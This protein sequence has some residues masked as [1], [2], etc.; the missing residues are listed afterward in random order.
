MAYLSLVSS[1]NGELVVGILAVVDTKGESAV[2]ENSV[3]GLNCS[4]S[5]N[6]KRVEVDG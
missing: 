1:D 2:S 4:H 5:S 6:G 3:P